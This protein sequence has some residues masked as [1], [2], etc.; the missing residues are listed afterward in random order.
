MYILYI[1]LYIHIICVYIYTYIYIC[2]CVCIISCFNPSIWVVKPSHDR[3]LFPHPDIRRSPGGAVCHSALLALDLVM[4]RCLDPVDSL[5]KTDAIFPAKMVV[6]LN[7]SCKNL[8]LAWSSKECWWQMAG[9]SDLRGCF[10]GSFNQFWQ[11]CAHGKMNPGGHQPTWI[12]KAWIQMVCKYI[13]FCVTIVSVSIHRT[14]KEK[15][16]Q[17]HQVWASS[18]TTSTYI[19]Q[20]SP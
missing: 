20:E 1:L 5:G 17:L 18:T 13:V 2:M 12:W 14:V 6:K 3:E 16:R 8:D 11:G 19:H 7:S 15:T 10:N 4:G 9:F